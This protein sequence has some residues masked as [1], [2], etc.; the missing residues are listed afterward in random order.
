MKM[1]ISKDICKKG[2]QHQHLFLNRIE[3]YFFGFG[4]NSVRRKVLKR[5]TFKKEL[6]CLPSYVS[7]KFVFALKNNSV[8]Q[9]RISTP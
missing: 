2:S 7:L 6:L 9:P 8:S 3:I 1:T 4:E 5:L